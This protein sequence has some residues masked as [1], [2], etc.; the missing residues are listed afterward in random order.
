LASSPA[1]SFHFTDED[2]AVLVEYKLHNE[3]LSLVNKGVDADFEAA[4]GRV[5]ATGGWN[6]QQVMPV[7]LTG[8][9]L[10]FLYG[11]PKS[12]EFDDAHYFAFASKTKPRFQDKAQ[13]FRFFDIISDGTC[14]RAQQEVMAKKYYFCKANPDS[15]FIP[16]FSNHNFCQKRSGSGTVF[17]V[18]D[19]DGD[20]KRKAENGSAIKTPR[21]V[22]RK[23][24]GNRSSNSGKKSATSK[25]GSG[26]RSSNGGKAL[27]RKSIKTE[28]ADPAVKAL[29][30]VPHARVYRL[31][32][33]SY[34]GKPWTT[35]GDPM[36]RFRQVCSSLSSFPYYPSF[37]TTN[38]D[39]VDVFPAAFIKTHRDVYLH[40][41]AL[42]GIRVVKGDNTWVPESDYVIKSDVGAMLTLLL[43]QN[44][45]YALFP[46][47]LN[48]SSDYDEKVHMRK[49]NKLGAWYEKWFNKMDQKTGFVHVTGYGAEVKHV[50]KDNAPKGLVIY[51]HLVLHQKIAGRGATG[52]EEI[53]D[54]TGDGDDDD[55]DSDEET[56]EDSTY[57][58]QTED[59]E[60]TDDERY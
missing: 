39:R 59:K 6:D 13:A 5:Q 24:T 56:A 17:K 46:Q 52:P 54:L 10:R 51:D 4:L 7:N 55:E 19:D 31:F 47:R 34:S 25:D 44:V 49:C 30:F 58:P 45:P 12:S 37:V 20:K 50:V 15:E 14:T 9:V 2:K 36:V 29:T 57:A 3:L 33:F 22:A 43:R 1:K 8:A 48:A 21:A 16:D 41:T 11:C 28:R 27:T 18:G 53:L 38:D 32:P 40:S 23:T 26:N 60:S 35:R 42:L